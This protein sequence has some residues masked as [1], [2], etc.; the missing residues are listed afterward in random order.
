VAA[1][2]TGIH[3]LSAPRLEP[4]ERP[5]PGEPL[6]PDA[7]LLPLVLASASPRRAALLAAAGL[8][9]ERATVEVD[10]RPL[11]G[12]SPADTC[13]RLACAKARAAAAGRSAGTLLAG[14]TLVAVD[15]EALGKPAGAAQALAMLR[16]LQGREHEVFSS[17]AALRARDGRLA[18]GV[19]RSRVRMAPLD[20]DA[21]GAY[22]AS[23]EWEGKAGAYAIQGR[24]GRFARV[25]EGRTD[26]VIGL[27][28]E[29]VAQLLQQLA[30]DA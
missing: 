19:A 10:E 14:D 5:G 15:G 26:T 22:V 28:V 20:E 25:V 3:G 21:L 2:A 11:P 6:R 30:E 27:S 9:F 13:L 24:A 1:H 18:S 23:G 8:A 17:A 16:R 12:E 7:R 29:L 4:G